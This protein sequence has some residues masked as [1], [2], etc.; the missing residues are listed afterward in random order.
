HNDL[1]TDCSSSSI[2]GISSE[3]P[4]ID[5]FWNGRWVYR[6]LDVDENAAFRK[7][8]EK[9]GSA[10][11]GERAMR[12]SENDPIQFAKLR[13][14]AKIETILVFCFLGARQRI[15]HEGFDSEFAEFT[16]DAGDPAVPQ[17][18]HV[19]FEGKAE[20]SDPRILYAPL[21]CDEHLD[22]AL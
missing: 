4:V 12:H 20:N 18:R 8:R 19:L 16:D 22:K 7:R 11:V 2:S 3:A 5:G 14:R 21:C 15:V 13:Y 10:I 6:R 17:V 1:H 9:P